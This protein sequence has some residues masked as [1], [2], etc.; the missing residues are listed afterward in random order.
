MADILT[1]SVTS[2][3]GFGDSNRGFQERRW[4]NGLLQQAEQAIGDG[5]SLSSNLT[6]SGQTV[7]TWSLGADSLSQNP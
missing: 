4:L 7:G 3:A 5:K 6:Y 1:I 2:R